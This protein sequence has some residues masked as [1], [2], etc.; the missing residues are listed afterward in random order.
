MDKIRE[1]IRKNEEAYI[2]FLKT[3]IGFDTSVIRHG[4][5]GQEYEA[6]K[7]VADYL[8]KLGCQ[9]EMFEL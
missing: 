5:D 8:E 6:Q 7:W 9:V 4:E 2:E 3:L 1:E